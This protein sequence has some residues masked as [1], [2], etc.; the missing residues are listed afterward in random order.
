MLETAAFR[1][2]TSIYRPLKN[3]QIPCFGTGV[4][5]VMNEPAGKPQ[6][7]TLEFYFL[8]PQKKESSVCRRVRVLCDIHLK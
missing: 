2:V 7:S 4:S 6:T 3:V 8:V 5:M 1:N